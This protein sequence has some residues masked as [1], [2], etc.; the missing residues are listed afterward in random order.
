MNQRW[1]GSSESEERDHVYRE[2]L[3]AETDEEK[4]RIFHSGGKLK[5]Q[6]ARVQL[7]LADHM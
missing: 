6:V 5:G 3:L 7:L 4:K 2:P 1:P